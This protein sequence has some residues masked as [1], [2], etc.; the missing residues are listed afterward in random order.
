MEYD[1]DCKYLDLI[2]SKDDEYK[3]EKENIKTDAAMKRHL[4]SNFIDDQL[5][6]DRTEASLKKFKRLHQ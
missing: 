6:L 3:K 4:D 2:K 1:Y 5:L